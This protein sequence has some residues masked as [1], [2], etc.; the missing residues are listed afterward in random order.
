VTGKPEVVTVYTALM[1]NGLMLYMIHVA[2]EAEQSKYSRA[3]SE[4]VRSMR[5]LS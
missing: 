3:F 4:M 1:N 2:P 5:L